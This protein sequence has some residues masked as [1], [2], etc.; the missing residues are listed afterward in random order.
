M[1]FREVSVNEI[2]EVLRVWLGVAGLPAPGYRTIAAHCGVDRKTVRRYVEAAQAAGL[3]RSDSVEA[4]DDGLIGAVAD[5]VRPVRPDGHGAAWEQL[6]GFEQQITA[7]VAGDGEQRPLT[8]T[9]IHTLL[10]RQGCLVPYRTLNRFAGE[11]CGFGA[12][13][14]TVRVTDGDPGV[15]CQIDF[16]YLGMLTDADDGRRRKVHA[17]IFTAVYSRHM[18]VWLSYSQ[19]LA[20]VIAGS[21]AAW[22]FFGGVFAVLIPD[23]LK[24]VIAAAD[25]VNPR[26]TQGWLDYASHVGFLT[27]PARVRSPKDKPRV[28]RAVQYVRGNFWDGETFTSLEEAQQAATAWCVRTAGTRI[29][30]STCARPLEV[31][32]TA[33]Q[34]LLLPAPGVYDVPVFKAVKVH[35][36]FHAEAAKAL[37]SLPEHWIGHTLDV[38]ADSELVKFYHRG[39]LVKVHPRQPPG[40]RSTDRA[41][42]PEHKAVY[43]MRDLAA[44]IATCAAHGPNIGIYAER[45]LDDPLPWTRMRTVY[46]LQGLVR[47]YGADRVERACSL[48]LDL[49]V[50]SVNKIASM[51]QRGTESTAPQLP[52]AVGQATTRFTR[53]PSEFNTPTTSLTIVTDETTPQEIR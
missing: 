36:D 25:A 50:V 53:C 1:A 24:P 18:F 8:I 9:K 19:T 23:N 41:D 38:R 39:V 33:E 48:S 28:E 6:V 22:D 30:G 14:T 46:R 20:A 34:A 51:L 11:R 32:T 3:R 52:R 44:L 17:L 27:D 13:D 47:R 37:Y 26:F 40:G 43:A 49:D 16:G 42:L 12:K 2:R 7:W 29:H 5:A 31:F 21:E 15:E 35:R 45:I 4:V 10:A